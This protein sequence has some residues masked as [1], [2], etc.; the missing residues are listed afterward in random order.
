MKAWVN[1]PDGVDR[2]V[3]CSQ[4]NPTMYGTVNPDLYGYNRYKPRVAE[5][6]VEMR[7]LWLWNDDD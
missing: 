4:T 3:A 1:V 5:D 6:T 7:E 2:I